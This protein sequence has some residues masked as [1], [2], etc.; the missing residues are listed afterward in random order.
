MQHLAGCMGACC[1]KLSAWPVQDPLVNRHVMFYEAGSSA[2]TLLP[3]WLLTCFDSFR[4][5]CGDGAG[6]SGKAKKRQEGATTNL[7]KMDGHRH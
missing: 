4:T 6:C 1:W 5:F 2:K 7:G 3:L